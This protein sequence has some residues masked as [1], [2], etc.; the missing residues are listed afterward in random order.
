M[1]IRF[2]LHGVSDV[3]PFEKLPPVI[4]G[5]DTQSFEV[6]PCEA[7]PLAT[8]LMK[9]GLSLR[10]S[11]SLERRNIGSCPQLYL[12]DMTVIPLKQSTV[13]KEGRHQTGSWYVPPLA[14]E[15]CRYMDFCKAS[16][17]AISLLRMRSGILT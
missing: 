3:R 14:P 2:S 17:R 11:S 13:P 5:L 15:S 1:S 7:S 16:T 10:D 9:T 12:K 6:Q 8:L 4:Q